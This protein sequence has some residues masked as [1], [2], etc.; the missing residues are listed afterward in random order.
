MRQF[1]RRAP[2][3]WHFK[4]QARVWRKPLLNHTFIQ[5]PSAEV[6]NLKT[7]KGE[8][9]TRNEKPESRGKKKTI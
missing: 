6:N 7:N 5:L 3:T 8:R 4:A 1:I 2:G 9:S